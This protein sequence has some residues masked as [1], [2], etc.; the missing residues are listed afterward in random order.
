MTGNVSANA[1]YYLKPAGNWHAIYL[2]FASAKNI[3]KNDRLT[4]K[5]RAGAAGRVYV[6]VVNGTAVI[7]EN[8]APAYNFMPAPNTWTE[9]V[10]DV[11]S[12]KDQPFTRLEIN[13]AVDNT[14]PAD[15]YI[16]D[17]ALSN[18]LSPN[19]EPVIEVSTIPNPVV[20][21]AT[22]VFDASESYD[23]DGSIV[24][25]EWD[26]GDGTADVGESV[27]HVYD[28][29]GIFK[30]ALR[31]TDNEGKQATRSWYVS[32]QPASGRI[33]AITQFTPAVTY[34]KVEIGF[35]LTQT[36][37]NVYDPDEVSVDALIT[38][39]DESTITVPCFFFEKGSYSAAGDQ[40][41]VDGSLSCWML[42]FT[43]EQTGLHTVV[44]QL[45][46]AEGVTSTQP[47]ETTFTAGEE[48]GFIQ[49]DE[50]EP[51]HYR[52]TTGQP[53]VPLGI[54]AG[55]GSTTQYNTI[56]T[57]Q[58]AGAANFVR[59][60]QV[61]FDR[62]GLE[63]KSGVSFYEGLGRYSQ[64][65]AAEQDSIMDLCASLGVYLQ[66]TIFQHGMFQ[67]RRLQLE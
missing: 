40:W 11:S 16:D 23:P 6:K 46:D 50:T 42:R 43:S 64:Q 57:N 39:P 24:S 58:S 29:D 59:Y 67:K 38:L 44:L 12:I 34:S 18:S 61:P 20:A 62:Q 13:A 25:H 5:L 36:Y 15:V 30:V 37:A 21:G 1:A 8:W 52:H 47:F 51:Q 10:L 3:G 53:Y 28:N 65:A 32:V 33:G 26:F 60:W 66:M 35:L 56:L 49:R 14:Q 17:F 31:I 55:W 27:D 48:K 4:F 9:C 63:W 2:G 41:S 19:G 54:N 22:A 45:T 7:L